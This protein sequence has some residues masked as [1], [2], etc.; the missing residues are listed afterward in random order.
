PNGAVGLHPLNLSHSAGS[1]NGIVGAPGAGKS[2][3]LNLLI[4]NL[5]PQSGELTS[6]GVS[7]HSKGGKELIGYVPQDDLL[8][9]EVTVFENLYYSGLL[10]LPGLTTSDLTVR[11]HAL[12]KRIDLFETRDLRVGSVLDK[13]ISGGQR[14]RLNIALELLREPAVL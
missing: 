3:L 12:L 8:I 2:T 14:K 10:C 7:V 4:G 1:M 5:Q 11:I 9:E 6:Q 13:R